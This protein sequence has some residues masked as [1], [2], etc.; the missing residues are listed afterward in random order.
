MNAEHSLTHSTS[1]QH[2]AA[3]RHGVSAIMSINLSATVW[4]LMT[5]FGHYFSLFW[6][7]L[8]HIATLTALVQ[9]TSL[10]TVG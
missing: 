4:I 6:S 5:H 9:M 7:D 10:V 1:S 2:S 8:G 3:T